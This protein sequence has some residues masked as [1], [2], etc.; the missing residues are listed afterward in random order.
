MN[1]QTKGEL[2]IFS[3]KTLL[4]NVM[5]IVS[6]ELDGIFLK[7]MHNLRYFLLKSES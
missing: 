6:K 5:K 1:V 2:L 3:N 4:N 7:K